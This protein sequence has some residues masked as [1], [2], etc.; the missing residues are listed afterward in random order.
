MMTTWYSRLACLLGAGLAA[1][2]AVP[3]AS[4]A[5]THDILIERRMVNITGRERPGVVFNGKLPGPVLRLKEGDE[6]VI[7]VTNHLNE[8][9][10][11]HWHGLILPPEMDGVPNISPQF[12]GIQ[13]GQTF[14]YRFKVQQA[15]TY[16]YHSH[17]GAQEQ[18]GM[19]GPIIIEPKRK[20]PFR[21]D[22]DYVVMLSDWTDED[23]KRVYNNLKVDGG[24]YNNNRQTLVGLLQDLGK[25]QTSE[26]RQRIV[27][28]RFAWQRMRMDPTDIADV[29]RYT[30]LVN[31]LTPEQNFTALF[32][33]GERVRLRFINAAAMTYFDVRIPGLK[34]TVVQ[35]DG[36]NVQPVPID[37]FRIA[38]AES[39]D[40]IVQP[41]A[42]KPYTIVAETMDRSGFARATLATQPGMMGQL[43]PHRPR[44]VLSMADMGMNFGPK[45]YD[46]GTLL[47]EQDAP[48]HVAP[49]SDM[50]MDGMDMGSMGPGRQGAG[51]MQHGGM[52]GMSGAAQ[53]DGTMPSAQP[54]ARPERRRGGQPDR[55]SPKPPS[56]P[57]MDHSTM[58]G[59][60][61]APPQGSTAWAQMQGMDHSTMPGMRPSQSAAQGGMTA[62]PG[63]SGE[64]G[65]RAGH[66]QRDTMHHGTTAG[67]AGMPHVSPDPV[68]NDTGAPPGAKVLSYR[69]LKALASP[70]GP[71]RYDRIIEI[72]L[73]GN[74]R[75]YF[76]S[77]NGR[78]FSEAQPITLRLGERA[79]FR[80]INE[81]MMNH[82]MHIHGTW[83]LPD[84]GNGARNPL[85]HVVNIKPGSTLDVDIPADAE[86]PWAFHCHL[87]YHMEAGM[88][89]QVNVVRSTAALR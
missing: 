25:A 12:Y 54:R 20:E 57:G 67:T 44:P 88:M 71:P 28:E 8:P 84:V 47:P 64:P 30:F 68:R 77:I 79:R 49:E 9:T 43:P 31:G 10:S 26:E 39:F 81:T 36:Q 86:G 37:E 78:K 50:G 1:A 42:D 82:P 83:M 60:S 11:I 85:K 55:S 51:G 74:M 6:A 24:Y 17:S 22:R 80:F 61:M 66:E 7:N 46:R 38:V 13:P 58:P 72:R 56:M 69:D 40:V 34:M 5:Q 2:F 63:M 35:A 18:L 3:V 27:G 53:P 33:P 70:Y 29:G 16:W 4:F 45:G 15:G 89:R 14:T 32:R 75:R 48:G 23:P 52:P 73:T 87:L 59:M 19:Y 65:T 41:T 21:Y 76:W 62:M